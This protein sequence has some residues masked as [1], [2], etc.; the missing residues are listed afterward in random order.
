MYDKVKEEM[1]DAKKD[2]TEE[3]K[4][5]IASA[6]MNR[7][8]QA[9]D[10][11][12]G[13]NQMGPRLAQEQKKGALPVGVF[14]QFKAAT[15]E[16]NE[17]L[18]DIKVE[19]DLVQPGWGEK[20]IPQC[21]QMVQQKRQFDQVVNP[22]FELR[23]QYMQVKAAKAAGQPVPDDKLQTSLVRRALQCCEYTFKLNQH[24]PGLAKAHEAK[25]LPPGM[26]EK[27]VQATQLVNM[28]QQAIKK[29]ADELKPG[30][31]GEPGWGSSGKIMEQANKIFKEQLEAMQKRQQMMQQQRAAAMKAQQAQAKMTP[32]QMAQAK[33]KAEKAYKELM[34]AENKKEAQRAQ[35]AAQ[36]KEEDTS[37]EDAA[38]KDV[39]AKKTD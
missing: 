11:A 24:G 30:E 12:L 18:E 22:R 39:D 14:D 33:A 25:A 8:C 35:A 28:E 29:E 7:C 38:P 15:K 20:I 1:E 37:T 5:K 4:K 36:G 32:E 16:V 26:F 23:N 3:G 21:S 10:Y 34:Q 6:L 19:A 13:F 9:V 2:K 27:F 31:D 17:E